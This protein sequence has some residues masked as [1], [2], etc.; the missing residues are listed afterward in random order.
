MSDRKSNLPDISNGG[1]S[2]LLHGSA[3]LMSPFSKEIYIGRQA[4]V[5]MRF[6]GGADSL[7]KDLKPGDKVTFLREPENEY[8]TQAVMAMDGKGRKLGYVPRRENLVM[9]ALMDHGKVFYGVIPDISPDEYAYSRKY[10]KQM[11]ESEIGIPVT[12]TVDL[13]MREFAIPEDVTVIPR[14]GCDGSYAVL[15]CWLSENEPDRIRRLCAIKVI[16]GEERGLLDKRI[17]MNGPEED[18]PDTATKRNDHRA[19]ERK[20]EER[21]AAGRR[22]EERSAAGRRAEERRAAGKR[23]EERRAL[24]EFDEFIGFLPIVSHG[25]NGELRKALEEAYGVLLGKP[26]SNLFIDTKEMAL[27]HLPEAD[28]YGLYSLATRLGFSVK[29]DS[30]AER[31]CRRTWELYRRMD[32][33]KLDEKG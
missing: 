9:S 25:I 22:A 5:G 30:H 16:N 33:S 11:I 13:Y 6:Q 8:D 12:V 23:A 27:N 1:L 2:A 20:E 26:L 7:I 31:S 14:H 4:I 19:G 15:S 24:R 28:D 29:G 32:K 3:G 17:P 21:S 10:P 18:F